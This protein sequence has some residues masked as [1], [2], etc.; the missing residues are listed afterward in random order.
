LDAVIHL[1]GESIAGL[2]WTRSK[3]KRILQSRVQGTRFLCQALTALAQPPKVLLTASAIGYYGNRPAPEEVDETSGKGRGFLPDVVEAWEAAAS[4]AGARGIR[5]VHMR[6]GMV[7]SSTGGA[8][9][10]MLLPFRLGLGGRLGCGQQQVSWVLLE[11][12]PDVVSHLLQTESC[13]GPV[14]VVTPNPVANRELTKAIAEV[15]RK[16]APFPV[17]ASLLRLALGQMGQELLLSGCRVLP[18]K[19]TES[20]YVFRYPEVRPALMHLLPK[21]R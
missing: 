6:F 5:V 9:P 3:K 7:L 10:K 4:E 21:D 2:R 20:G 13:S 16:P 18:R 11:E 15:L 14:N 8:F 17:P 19:L 1:A 12:I